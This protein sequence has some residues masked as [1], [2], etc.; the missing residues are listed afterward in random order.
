MAALKT[1]IELLP[2]E[3]WEKTT[4]GKILAWSLT[5]GRWIVIV[6][7]LVVI[8][9][10]LSRF[11]LDRDLTDLNEKVKQQQSI[12]T[13]S[14]QF[15]KEFRFLQKRIKTIENLYLQQLA[16][17][18]L[19]NDL[20]ALTPLDVTLSDIRVDKNQISLKANAS[21]EAGLSTFINNLKKSSQFDNVTITKLGLAQEGE[22]GIIF[23]LKTGIKKT[24]I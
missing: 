13:A 1:N 3:E 15:E 6:T 4:F 17:E 14:S 19:L 16:A 7:E 5:V 2:Q 23:E 10:F 8:M 9:A 18:K 20:A 22:M 11:K 24:T 21:S 12:I